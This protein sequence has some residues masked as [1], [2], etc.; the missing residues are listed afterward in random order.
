MSISSQSPYHSSPATLFPCHSSCIRGSDDCHH[1][2]H[3]LHAPRLS[4]IERVWNQPTK[5]KRS[6]HHHHHPAPLTPPPLQLPRAVQIEESQSLRRNAFRE[7]LIRLPQDVDLNIFPVSRQNTS[8]MS[9]REIISPTHTPAPET[10]STSSL[11]K[12][13]PTRHLPPI[14]P[15]RERHPGTVSPQAKARRNKSWPIPK[16]PRHLET[17]PPQAK[18]RRNQ[19]WP[20]PKPPRHSEPN[21]THR[22]RRLFKQLRG[23]LA[24]TRIHPKSN[25]ITTSPPS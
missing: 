15:R 19:S 5:N 16:P 25:Q 17:S 14:K 18:A 24:T 6:V 10:P 23:H 7:V 8:K 11:P 22:L 20:I 13:P 3:H 1:A 12:P 9:Y 21:P 4:Y 2:N